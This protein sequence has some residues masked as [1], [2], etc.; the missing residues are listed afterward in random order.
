MVENAEALILA[1]DYYKGVDMIQQ[2]GALFSAYQLDTLGLA[3][4]GLFE[5]AMASDYLPLISYATGFYITRRGYEQSL[6]LLER[7]RKAGAG[8]S[9]AYALQESL[10]R[11][12]AQRDVAETE[13]LN[14]KTMLKV[15]TGGDK[16][17][18]R[19]A[20]VYRYHVE[21]R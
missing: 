19:F 8:A 2:A 15:Y 1:G 17:Y 16:W 20:D 11:G 18:R 6:Q 12:L 5:M 10:A 7:M 21:S 14:L 9:D 13:M 4:T 3:N